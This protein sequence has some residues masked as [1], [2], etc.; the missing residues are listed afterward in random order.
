MKKF[1]VL[2]TLG[3][4]AELIKMAPVMR[5]LQ[6]Q[7]IAYYYLHVGQHAVLDMISQLGIKKPDSILEI[8]TEKRGRF[9][10]IVEAF[11]WGVK[12]FF[13][14][15]N[16]IM[17]V[18]P[19]LVICH[20]DTMTTSLVSVATKTIPNGPLLA[21]VEAGI[22]S[23]DY[24]EPF[25]EEIMRQVTD[26]FADVHF[27]PTSRAVKNLNNAWNIHKNKIFLTGN[28]NVDVL[29]HSL[30]IAL[31]KS[32]F[33]PPN[34]PYILAQMHRQ[35]NIKSRSRCT[36]FIETLIEIKKP[37]VFIYL[38][39]TSRQA[40]KFD[41]E[42]KLKSAKHITLVDNLAYF[43]FLKAFSKASAVFTD[44]G[45]ETEEAATVDKPCIVFRLKT[46][47]QEAEES[48][49]AVRV[50]ADK[51]QA[52]HYLNFALNRKFKFKHNQMPFGDGNASKR[53]VDAIKHILNINKTN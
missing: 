8:S 40:K 12:K 22:R 23:G 27:A 26:F 2:I 3:T 4:R 42:E 32:N 48:G 14:I 20:G 30:P 21:H 19:R 39:N 10:K 5:E 16:E 25:P 15:R 17:N 52:L 41:L 13:L 34:K 46:E 37:V 44:G 9:Q 43:D 6:K 35:E 1:P 51:K 18:K 49:A 24:L 11:I 7:R 53:I 28:T 31:K 29:L 47:R 36:S 50:G 33:H 38:E 45:G